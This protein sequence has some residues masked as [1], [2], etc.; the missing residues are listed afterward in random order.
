MG[1]A[2]AFSMAV[3]GMIEDNM[4]RMAESIAAG[5]GATAELDFGWS[6]RRPSI[7]RRKRFSPLNAPAIWSAVTTSM[8]RSLVM[9]SE[10]F[11]HMLNGGA[12]DMATL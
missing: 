7:T 4:R 5:F 10:D 9:A 3:M 12:T 6:L 2:R 8:K 1:T 11:I